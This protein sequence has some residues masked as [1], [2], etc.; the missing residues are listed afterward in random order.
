MSD[1]LKATGK[2]VYQLIGE[3]NKFTIPE[4]DRVIR[5]AFKNEAPSLLSL[6]AV[7]R[8]DSAFVALLISYKH[9]YPS[10]ALDAIP[11]QLNKLLTL[12]NVA[13]WFTH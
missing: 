7:S 3:F 4:H 2:G 13:K 1:C 12:Y 9:D 5:A 8:C 6:N 10:L 11:E